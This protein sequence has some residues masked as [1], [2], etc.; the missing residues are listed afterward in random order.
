M[1][2]RTGVVHRVTPPQAASIS[3][4]SPGVYPRARRGFKLAVPGATP[5]SAPAEA[6]AV[7]TRS[8]M[9]QR[10]PAVMSR[11][12]GFVV[13]VSTSNVLSARAVPSGHEEKR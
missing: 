5:R 10:L 4:Q 6:D 12:G 7:D 1:D 13:P 2:E 11:H 8:G 9:P 3:P